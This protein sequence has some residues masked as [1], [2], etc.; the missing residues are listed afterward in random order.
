[1]REFVPPDKKP[2]LRSVSAEALAFVFRDVFG[3]SPADYTIKQALNS[4]DSLD[5]ATLEDL[6]RIL[7][8]SEFRETLADAYRDILKMPPGNDNIFLTS[9]HA[10]ARDDKAAVKY[11]K[12]QAR[13]EWREI[14]QIAS[15][16]MLSS[17]PETVGEAIEAIESGSDVTEWAEALGATSECAI[18]GTTIV[19]PD[20]F[21]EAIVHHYELSD[22]EATD[23]SM[24]IEQA[25]LRSGTETG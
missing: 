20:T 14:D 22:P 19:P 11:I 24:R 2:D 7:A 1:M 17:L 4:C 9:L 10:L 18:C 16:E 8:R 15:R 25:L 13:R 23:A 3:R 12:R 6:P 5:I 21:A